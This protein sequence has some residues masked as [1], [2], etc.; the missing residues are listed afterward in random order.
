MITVII[1]GPQG[2][3]KSRVAVGIINL[4]KAYGFVSFKVFTTNKDISTEEM[5]HET[6][7]SRISG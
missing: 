6:Y 7:T 4:L 5:H 1:S 3:G 2:I